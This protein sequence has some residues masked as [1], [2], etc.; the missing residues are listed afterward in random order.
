MQ[1]GRP[2]FFSQDRVLYLWRCFLHQYKI[3]VV[4]HAFF[5][6]KNHHPALFGVKWH[7]FTEIVENWSNAQSETYLHLVSLGPGGIHSLQLH[8]FDEV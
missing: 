6:S 8:H 1:L 5:K 3:L 7:Q 4:P 2:Q